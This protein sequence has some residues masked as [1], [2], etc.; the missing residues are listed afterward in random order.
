MKKTECKLMDSSAWLSY[1]FA[2]STLIKKIVESETVLYTSVI[3]LF[4][5]KRKLLRDGFNKNF[6]DVLGFIKARSII[7]NLDEA[8][9]QHAADISFSQKLHALD[10]LIYST[11]KTMN[12]QLVT[13]DSDFENLDDVIVIRKDE[14][15]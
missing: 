2:T 11:A 15:K 8:I 13:A 9:S 12:A 3:S 7:I 10:A 5:I 6:E 14:H 1:F 4:E